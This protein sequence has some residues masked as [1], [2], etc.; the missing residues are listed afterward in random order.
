MR[1]LRWCTPAGGNLRSAS[2]AGDNLR[3]G[4]PA[5]VYFRRTTISSR[6]DVRWR[7]CSRTGGD[8][9][10][11][12]SGHTN[13]IQCRNGRS[14]DIQCGC[15]WSGDIQRRNGW[16]CDYGWS[17][18]IQRG[19]GCSGDVQRPSSG[20][21]QCGCGCSGDILQRWC[22]PRSGDIRRW[23][24]I[25]LNAAASGNILSS[26]SGRGNIR[27]TTNVWSSDAKHLC[28]PW[29]SSGDYVLGKQRALPMCRPGKTCEWRPSR[30]NVLS[31]GSLCTL[32]FLSRRESAKRVVRRQQFRFLL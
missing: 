27:C 29:F 20:D 19:C 18:D 7:G 15:G 14:H 23:G 5:A 8:V 4:S 13:Y 21:I 11:T 28:G 25:G 2:P 12:T 32:V 3:S 16:F 17:H 30:D 1:H 31:A 22:C 24:W 26:P 6:R 9:R 10:S